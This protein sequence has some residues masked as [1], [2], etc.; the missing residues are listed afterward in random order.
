M[1]WR[2]ALVLWLLV[3]AAGA[4][5]RADPI[6][7]RALVEQCARQASPARRG[8]EALRTGCPEI[9]TAIGELGLAPLL[10]PDWKKRVSARALEDWGA[11]ADRYARPPL[12]VLP[13]A[14]S[15]RMIAQRMALPPEPPSWWER[16]KSWLASWLDSDG[17][18]W[19]DWLRGLHLSNTAARLLFY[20]LIAVVVITA[21]VV[22]VREL[23]AAGV[24]GAA[25]RRTPMRASAAA[26]PGSGAGTLVPEDVDAAPEH[27]RPVILLRLLVT[28]LSRAHRLERAGVLT[29]REL[30]AAARFDTPGQRDVFTRVALSA[31]QVLYADPRRPAVPLDPDLL[32][33]ARGLYGQ[34]V[35]APVEQLAQ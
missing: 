8:L 16:F 6:A 24:F 5:L 31:E 2:R 27:L 12:G 13:S 26:S 20:G 32:G 9:D 17:R 35:A 7:P 30:I 19:P 33:N 4:P 29:C 10:P 21:A 25:R 23:R 22:I 15:L 14:P 28:A 3:L 11:L 18:R 34:L 1:R